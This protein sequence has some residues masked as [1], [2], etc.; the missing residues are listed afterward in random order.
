MTTEASTAPREYVWRMP[1]GW[2]TRKRH[3]LLYMAREFTSVPMA[4]WLIWLLFEIKRAGN[5]PHGYYPPES[6]AFVVFSVIVLIFALYHSYTFLKLAGVII[7]VKVFDRPISPRLI[8][9]AMFGTWAA[10]SLVVG[11]VLIWF[12]R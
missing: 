6:T 2:W 4:L 11:F 9:L 1:A 12:S 8:V 5:G 3:Y 7:R 10:A